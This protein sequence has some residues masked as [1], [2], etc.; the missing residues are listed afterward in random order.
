MTDKFH[1]QK[2]VVKIG[3]TK[4]IKALKINNKFLGDN[5]GHQQSDSKDQS[6]SLK[7]NLQ[8]TYLMIKKQLSKA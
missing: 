8:E 7:S 1:P 2:S 5:F 3:N 4:M 6:R